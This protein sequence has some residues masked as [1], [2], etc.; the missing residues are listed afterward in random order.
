VEIE[1]SKIE[2]KVRIVVGEE[3]R[4]NLKKGRVKEV[5]PKDDDE[6]VKKM[7]E[8]EKELQEMAQGRVIELFNAVRVARTNGEEGSGAVKRE[9]VV[10]IAKREEKGKIYPHR[11]Q[12]RDQMLKK[13][14]IDRNIGSGLLK[15]HP[16][17]WEMTTSKGLLPTTYTRAMHCLY[18]LYL[19]T[20]NFIKSL[21][22]LSL[23]FRGQRIRTKD[24]RLRMFSLFMRQ[25]TVINPST[26]PG[27]LTMPNMNPQKQPLLRMITRLQISC[28]T[29]S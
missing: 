6:A 8:L 25:Q 18:C 1:E 3:M 13:C 4:K 7:L 20:R 28:Q 10:G 22:L 15:S 27:C 29:I 23:L 14:Y 17:R 12:D 9:G 11:F 5:V 19:R 16:V 26:H 2:A 21:R 24:A